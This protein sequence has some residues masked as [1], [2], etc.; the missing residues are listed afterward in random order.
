[1]PS[2]SRGAKIVFERRQNRIDF[3]FIQG[4]KAALKVRS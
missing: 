1:M 2:P 4:S 3:N